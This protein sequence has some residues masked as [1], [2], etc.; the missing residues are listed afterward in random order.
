MADVAN[1]SFLSNQAGS[2]PF[3]ALVLAPLGG[4]NIPEYLCKPVEINQQNFD[5]IIRGFA[6][7]IDVSVDND[8]LCKLLNLPRQTLTLSYEIESYKD[9]EPLAILKKD[10]SLLEISFII[11]DIHTLL[12]QE[13]SVFGTAAFAFEH[14]AIQALTKPQINRQGLEVL[15][16]ELEWVLSEV[17]N[18]ILHQQNWQQLEAAW[19]G[20]YLLCQTAKN[21][22]ALI[23][24]CA[25]VTKE[26][27]WDDL[28]SS[29]EL[30]DSNLYQQIYVDSIGQYGA[31]P[32]GALLLDDY[33][34]GTG[35]DLTLLKGLTHIC[36]E[37]HL[38]VITAASANMFNVDDFNTLQDSAY[39]SEIHSTAAYIKW[40]SYIAS[41]EASFLTLTM[42]RLLFRNVYDKGDTGLSWFQEFTGTSHQ[43]CLWGNASYGFVDNLLKSFSGNGF[44]LSISGNEGGEIELGALLTKQA[45][46]PVEIAFSEDKEAE[47]I[48]LGFNP[49]C[50]RAFQNKLLFESANSVR[51][52]NMKL[53]HKVQNLDSIASS[54]LQYLLIVVRIIHCLKIIFRES[55]GATTSAS[56]LSNILNRWVRQFVS[57]VEAPSRL[58]R[59]QRPLKDARVAVLETLDV[60]WFDIDI[61]LTPHMKY[62]GHSVDINMS[63]PMNEEVS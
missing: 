60:G 12:Q 19:R 11:E 48:S 5:Q 15:V 62:L 59:S 8:A 17:L 47:L 31:I 40:R 25:T 55:L 6:P 4:E 38:P 51:W 1:I 44:C 46:L 13:G 53:N 35:S 61:S 34:S 57:D 50:T 3:K 41:E 54:Q 45:N 23:I 37:A 63:V 14:V 2:V 20:I 26:L 27:L 9:F 18:Q 16:C 29:S 58:V 43:Y 39:I 32:Y 42:P 21:T 52:G 56:E 10:P 28:F 24:E 36:S 49:V 22:D 7:C 33:F 30:N